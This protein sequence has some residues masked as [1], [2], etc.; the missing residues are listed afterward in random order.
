MQ[1]LRGEG[2]RVS[3]AERVRTMKRAQASTPDV[4]RLGRLVREPLLH[5]F[6]IGALIFVAAQAWRGAHDTRRIV[7]GNAGGAPGSPGST[8]SV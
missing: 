4:G 2:L 5:F 8:S 1:P 6:V 3:V 7:D